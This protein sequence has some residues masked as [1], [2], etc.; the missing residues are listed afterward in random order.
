MWVILLASISGLAV[1][2]EKNVYFF[3]KREKNCQ[4][5]EKNQLYKHLEQATEKKF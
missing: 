1:I 4:K 5:T 3:I 2:I